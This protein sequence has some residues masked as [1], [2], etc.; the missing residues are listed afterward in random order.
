MKITAISAQ[1]RNPE[2]VNVSVDGKYAFSLTINQVI[3]LGIRINNEYS[4]AELTELIDESSFGKLYARGL[5]YCLMRPHSEKEVRDYLWR[6]TRPTR[7]KLGQERPGVSPAIADRVLIKLKDKKYIDDENFTRYWTENRSLTKGVSKR[8]LSAE[9]YA[10]GVSQTIIEQA[11]LSSERHDDDE[12]QKII[13]KKQARYPDS[14]KFMMYLA[15]QGFSYD[16]I[17]R[18]LN[19]GDD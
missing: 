10:K 4:E 12:L 1:K 14:Q 18:A 15:R 7:D 6:K 2:R 9:L 13:A 8:K 19:K 17:K 5:D 16:D 11:L 3:D